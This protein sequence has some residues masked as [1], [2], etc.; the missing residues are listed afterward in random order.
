MI[1]KKIRATAGESVIVGTVVTVSPSGQGLE[2]EVDGLSDTVMVYSVDG[3]SIE[4]IQELP[5]LPGAIVRRAQDG[6]DGALYVR[7]RDDAARPAAG[8]AWIALDDLVTTWD[9]GAIAA[10]GFEVLFEGVA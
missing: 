9:D 8:Y 4:V 2:V 10:G 3:W 5:T 1:E 6:V 7:G